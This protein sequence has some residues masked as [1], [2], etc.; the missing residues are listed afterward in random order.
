MALYEI[1]LDSSYAGQSCIN[2]WNYVASGSSGSI[3]G[4]QALMGALG[5]LP[6]GDPPVYPADTV[7]DK[8]RDMCVTAVTFT[9]VIAKNIYDPTDFWTASFIPGTAGKPNFQGEPPFTAFG[10]RTTR[11]RSDI[12]RG[13]KRFVGVPV[14][15]STGAGNA[16]TEQVA[17]MDELAIA[18]SFS[19]TWDADTAN[20]TFQPAIVQKEK[21][22]VPNS[23]PE[24]FAYRYYPTLTEQL[25]HVMQGFS[26][27]LYP[28]F[29]SQTSRQYGKGQ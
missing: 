28:Q 16:N 15:G 23:T 19:V 7:F 11:T 8:I 4:A 1:V 9:Q 24:R 14:N 26:W 10:F 12:A 2:R 3:T 5:F 20:I 27:E 25:T 21:Y 17:L 13:T 29:R 22:V 6:L 18:M